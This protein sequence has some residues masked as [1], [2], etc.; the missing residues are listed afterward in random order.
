M[1]I[2]GNWKMHGSLGETGGIVKGLLGRVLPAG[3]SMAVFPP[4]TALSL[5]ADLLKDSPI[6]LGAQDCHPANKGA[7]TGDIAAPMLAELGCQYVLVG[8]SERRQYHVETD[9]LVHQK[10]QAARL[11]GI[12]P[13]VCV[14]ETL[15]E[16]QKGQAEA[17][18]ARQLAD[19]TGTGI[20]AYE[21]VWAIGTGLT[22]TPGDIIAMHAHIAQLVPG[23]E[24]LYGGSVKPENAAEILTLPGV[25]G[26]LVGG[27]SLSAESFFKIA[28]AVKLH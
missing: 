6:S 8:H 13:I 19:F 18:V 14:G 16:R 5:A 17:V 24:I 10:A 2:A 1:L 26:A 21:P 4:F 27:A 11:A 3:V 7:F 23:R 20:I 22:P 15:E 12:T 25:G 28:T 9:A